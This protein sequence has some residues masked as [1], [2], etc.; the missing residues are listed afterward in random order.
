MSLRVPYCNRENGSTL[1]SEDSVLVSTGLSGKVSK[2]SLKCSR[3]SPSLVLSYCRHWSHSSYL[4]ISLIIVLVLLVSSQQ[5]LRQ[6]QERSSRGVLT[7][8]KAKKARL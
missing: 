2:G 7:S 4:L 6:E 1:I 5:A 8:E 3:V